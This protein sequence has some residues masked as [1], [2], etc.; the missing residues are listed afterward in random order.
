MGKGSLTTSA[1]H[2]YS[3]Q[4]NKAEGYIFKIDISNGALTTLRELGTSGALDCDIILHRPSLT[5]LIM[6]VH[7][8]GLS[9]GLVDIFKIDIATMNLD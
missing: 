8:N 6:T 5:K 3:C 4:I 2:L 1:T 7:Y 9:D